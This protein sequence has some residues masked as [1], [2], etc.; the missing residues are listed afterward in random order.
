MI[1]CWFE[2]KYVY[3][4]VR[5]LRLLRVFGRVFK[6]L[7]ERSKRIRS[8]NFPMFESSDVSFFLF[9]SNPIIVPFFEEQYSPHPLEKQNNPE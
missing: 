2:G 8:L 5:L 6:E 7:Y 9:K 3:N 1:K 4:S